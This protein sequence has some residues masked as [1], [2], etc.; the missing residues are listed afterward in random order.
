MKKYIFF[1]ICLFF[2][3]SCSRDDTESIAN[4]T[5]ILQEKEDFS[6]LVPNSWS[7]ITSDELVTPKSWEIVLAF[8][9]ANQRQWYI[10][11]VVILRQENTTVSPSEI[12]NS[13]IQS[14]E[15]WIKWYKLISNRE[16]EFA[17]DVVGNIITYTWKYTS[18]TP[19]TVYVQSARVCWNDAYYMTISLTEK[20]ESY[21]RYEFILQNFQ[22]R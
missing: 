17:D 11:N 6:I 12:L 15:K 2:L 14:L 1:T 4:S 19:E 8:K 3:V 10:N 13:W 22:C 9:S 18:N 21:D 7:E 5:L 20:L 16:V